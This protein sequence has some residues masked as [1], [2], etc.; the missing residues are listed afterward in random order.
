MDWKGLAALVTAIAGAIGLLASE[1]R[2]SYVLQPLHDRTHEEA[3]DYL[4]RE[5]EDIRADLYAMRT[6][7]QER[8]IKAEPEW[9]RIRFSDIRRSV[10]A[11]GSFD[12]QLEPLEA[13]PAA[14]APADVK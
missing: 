7:S 8:R 4:Q 10:E 12:R 2:R 14:A 9:R 5:I 1:L 3:F 11:S 13:A 6:G